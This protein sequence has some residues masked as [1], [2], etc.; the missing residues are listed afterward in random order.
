[1]DLTRHRTKG[2]LY[3]VQYG[4]S[5]SKKLVL[6]DVRSKTPLTTRSSLKSGSLDSY[7]NTDAKSSNWNDAKSLN[8]NDANLGQTSAN[9]SDMNF[10][11]KSAN[12]SDLKSAN[13]SRV[14]SGF[15]V[16]S[17]TLSSLGWHRRNTLDLMSRDGSS[18]TSGMSRLD[19]AL[20]SGDAEDSNLFVIVMDRVRYVWVFFNISID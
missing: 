18:R 12:F 11:L 4:K 8:W 13:L 15:S 2:I 19:S 9:F 10:G 5:G 20:S 1:M 7:M 3:D 6:P 16:G 14:S 17:R